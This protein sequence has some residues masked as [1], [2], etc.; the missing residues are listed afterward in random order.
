MAPLTECMKKGSFEGIITTQRPLN[1]SRRGFVRLLSCAP[2]FELLFE[3]EC[4]VNGVGIGAAL[5]QC[6]HPLPTLMRS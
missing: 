4:N 2:N 3:V 1:Q 5:I 6:K